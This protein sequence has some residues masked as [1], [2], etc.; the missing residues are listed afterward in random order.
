[1]K[2]T[3]CTAK[4]ILDSRGAPTLE[5]K[6]SAGDFSV[7]ASVPSGKSTGGEEALELRDADGRG[8]SLAIANVNGIIADKI[9]GHDMEPCD[10]DH[11][12]L[13][14]DGTENKSNLG[15]NA[16]LG[17]S[18]A[19]TKLAAAQIGVP[20]WKY[21]ARTNGADPKLPKLFM[22]IINGGAHADFQPNGEAGRFRLPFQEYMIVPEDEL[23][24]VAYRQALSIIDLL[25]K[26]LK[27][28]FGDVPIGDEGGYSPLLKTIEEPFEILT[29]LIPKEGMFMAIDSA[30]S[31]FYKPARLGGG[32]GEYNLLDKSYSPE[33]LLSVYK[34]LTTRF[35]LLSIE[36]PFEESDASSFAGLVKKIGENV[37]IVG[38]DLTVT[39]PSLVT[40]MAEKKAANAV[41]IKP[42]QIGTLSEVYEA[43]TLAHGAGWKTIASHRSGETMD[44]FIADLA[45]GIGAYGIKAGSPSQKERKVKYD[46]LLEIEKEFLNI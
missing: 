2:I 42:N 41:I 22:N 38:D 6:M 44:S 5:V 39:N 37:L 33:E 4:E 14:L 40:Q 9:I 31:E 32:D 35:N 28:D 1:M 18:I 45:V 17:V 26:K 16:M 43:V 30:A 34:D 29:S 25:G 11:L 15:A 7:T 13:E 21:I 46:R 19:A 23:V 3:T 24:S 27:A 10:I 36:D 20:V 12:L 8:V